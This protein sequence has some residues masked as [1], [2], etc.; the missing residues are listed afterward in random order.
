METEQFQFN[1]LE[2]SA[3]CLSVI[4]GSLI[5]DFAIQLAEQDGEEVQRPLT[6]EQFAR[7]FE[8]LQV[9]RGYLFLLLRD[10]GQLPEADQ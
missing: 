1:A 10:S 9:E 4:A 8:V 5:S 7:A 6:K 2:T 3:H